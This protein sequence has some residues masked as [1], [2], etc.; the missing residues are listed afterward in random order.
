MRT[1][2][3]PIVLLIA[4]LLH[5]AWG[6]S[7]QAQVWGC[8]DSTRVNYA[9]GVLNGGSSHTT[10]SG[11]VTG[12]GATLA[13]PTPT[14]TPAYLAGI[15]VFYTSLLT[16]NNTPLS[17]AEQTALQNWLAA[18]GTLIV[19]AD[20][21]NLP[22]YESFTSFA[23]V[24]GY[25]AANTTSP[26]T[27]AAAHPITSGISTA[28]YV[29][30]ATF[31]VPGTALR[32]LNNGSG[33]PFA[34]VLDG[35]TGYAGPGRI[36]V[37]GDHNMFAD[38]LIGQ[39]DNTALAMNFI[40]WA[41][42]P[43]ARV[44]GCF[45]ATRVNYAGG[46][47]NGGVSHTT[48]AGLVA[49][50]GGVLAAPTPSLTAS[51]LSGIDVF[52][53]S[54]LTNN[55][56]PLSGAEQS[57][58]QNW[59]AGGGTLIVTADIFN[60]PGYESFTSFAGVTGYSAANT[61][62]PAT[63]AAS[64]PITTGISTAA[65]T[66][67]ATFTV[68]G[69]ALRILSNGSGAPFAC[70]LDGS[71]G[72]AGPGRIA[73]FGDHNMFSNTFIGQ[74][75]NTALA[76]NLIRWANNPNAT[77]WG[78]FDATRVNYAGGVLNGGASHTT[79]AGLVAAEGGV[80]AAPTAL[81]TPSYLSGIDVFY[82]SLLTNNNV[83]L[84][85][86]EQTALQNWLAGGGT[87][88]VTAD[89]FNLPGYQS[90]TS[91]A[92]VTGYSAANTASPATV[93]ASHPITAG[94]STAAYITDATFTVPGA[95]LRIMNNGSGG[96]FACVL[97]GSTG[98]AGPGRIAVFGDH[99]MFSNNFIGSAD[100]TALAI[101]LIRWAGQGGPP[102]CE[103]DLTTGAIAGQPGYGVPNGVVS[104][105]DFFYYLAQFASGNVAVADLTTGAIPGQPGYGV[106]NGVITNDD[107]FYY[108]AIFA[109]GC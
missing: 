23:G 34:C 2:F 82:T 21:F 98:Y 61:T 22:G 89:V 109:A 15:D 33:G 16:N 58:L 66:T 4:A 53:T 74:A 86:A 101:N 71:T 47:L 19:T 90:F 5:G 84:S 79:L 62:S 25:A 96:P 1:C 55:N 52:Y 51:Y 24:T 48:L 54:L 26:A 12:S 41:N 27:V 67:D 88:I 107:F 18:G 78:C 75:D 68:P 63:V 99:N 37:F 72:Y 65:Y 91:F 10:L 60:L 93:A 40:Q 59:L 6:A 106:P 108:L 100:N 7:A 32:I 77:V 42:N 3:H 45:D 81:L 29:T 69:A 20:I 87:L 38:S 70:A 43:N 9:G 39:A 94:I 17:G 31:T 44:W 8:F 97:D 73:V 105:D 49:A 102:P 46:V 13:A 28:A 104:N 92:G 95:A 83:P 103:P 85:G 36:A 50:E 76:I 14:L 56:V 35:S 11:L 80:L 30:D 64:H 57:A